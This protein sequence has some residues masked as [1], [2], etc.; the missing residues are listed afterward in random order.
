L[1]A[2][3][4]QD[5]AIVERPVVWTDRIWFSRGWRLSLAVATSAVIALGYMSLTNTMATHPTVSEM[6]RVAAIEETM[7][8]AGWTADEAATFARRAAA[9]A[10]PFAWSMQASAS[11]QMLETF[12]T[13]GGRR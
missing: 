7:R 13:S 4:L 5:S 9:D 6:A 2:R 8:D 11:L 10:R 1:R 3:V 12:E